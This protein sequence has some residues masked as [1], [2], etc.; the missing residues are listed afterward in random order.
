PVDLVA[1]D[2][3]AMSG[4][5]E[6][7][8]IAAA[9]NAQ[10]DRESTG[11]LRDRQPQ[12]VLAAGDRRDGLLVGALRRAGVA[13]DRVE[14]GPGSHREPPSRSRAFLARRP[15]RVGRISPSPAT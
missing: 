15:C 1:E 8:V 10:I 11:D 9:P 3:E 4:R 5:A 7:A 13:G 2:V 12:L 6:D 14:L